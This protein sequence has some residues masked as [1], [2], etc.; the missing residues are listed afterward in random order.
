VQKK[1][2][3]SKHSPRGFLATG[4]INRPLR[5]KW[6]WMFWQCRVLKE[7]IIVPPGHSS[8]RELL[9]FSPCEQL[10][11]RKQK[12][13]YH[14]CNFCFRTH[15]KSPVCTGRHSLGLTPQGLIPP[16]GQTP[17]KDSGAHSLA[18]NPN[19]KKQLRPKVILVWPFSTLVALALRPLGPRRI[20]APWN[21]KI[22]RP[23]SRQVP[24]VTTIHHVTPWCTTLS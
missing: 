7:Y 6:L 10:L 13:I 23:Y 24:I 21:W 18:N 9:E 16:G 19:W 2:T 3:P 17:L 11:L 4:P 22:P 8:S 12:S 15:T 14:V 5:L 1:P 20:V